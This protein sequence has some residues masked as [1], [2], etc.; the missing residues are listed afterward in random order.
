[1]ELSQDNALILILAAVGA[2][3]LALHDLRLTQAEHVVV[4]GALLDPAGGPRWKNMLG[5]A[6][7][8]I[9]RR[10]EVAK[11]SGS[12]DAETEAFHRPEPSDFFNESHYYNGSDEA[13]QD[14]VVTRISR[15]G[16]G[17]NVSYVFLLLDLAEHGALTLEA[18]DVP[19]D[20]AQDHPAA[21]GVSYVCEVPMRRWRLR[22][23]GL[24]RRGHRDAYAASGRAADKAWDGPGGESVRVKLDLVYERDSP[25]FWRVPRPHCAG[26]PSTHRAQESA[27][28]KAGAPRQRALSFILSPW[29]TK[30]LLDGMAKA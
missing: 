18:D 22:Y 11:S 17:A 13:T 21:L 2:L 6:M 3:L 15:R 28:Q 27:T 9:A 29:K 16:A 1:M 5:E 23:D 19:V 7:A 10:R 25:V 12:T 4:D 24:L 30:L 26:A 20:H 14:R 8:W